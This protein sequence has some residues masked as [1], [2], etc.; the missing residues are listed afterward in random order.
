[1][2][3]GVSVVS[4]SGWFPNGKV[5]EETSRDTRSGLMAEPADYLKGNP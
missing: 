4:T 2:A 1:M 3:K 5:S